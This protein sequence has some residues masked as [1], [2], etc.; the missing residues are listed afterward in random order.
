MLA[1][2]QPGFSPSPKPRFP[3]TPPP[4]LP[5][6]PPPLTHTRVADPPKHRRPH[7]TQCALDDEQSGPARR[8]GAV[9][10]GRAAR[11]SAILGL[12]G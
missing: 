6:M 2:L 11:R 12:L 1:A 4:A 3:L 8:D 10:I 7:R 9:R 5:T